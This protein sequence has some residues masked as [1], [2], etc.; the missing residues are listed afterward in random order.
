MWRM[1]T[2]VLCNVWRMITAVLCNVWRM[3]TAVLCNVW[4]M[5]TAVRLSLLVTGQMV[6]QCSWNNTAGDLFTKS[7]ISTFLVHKKPASL[8]NN[9]SPTCPTSLNRSHDQ[10]YRDQLQC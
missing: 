8:S 9:S 10:L 1:V 6:Q 2:A 4:G 7:Q 3:V 5:V